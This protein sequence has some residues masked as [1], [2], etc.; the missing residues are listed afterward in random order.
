VE[1]TVECPFHGFRYESSGRCRL[2]PANGKN[3]SVPPRFQVSSYR[4]FEKHGFIWIWWG[5][6][7]PKEREPYFFEDIDDSFSSS[8]IVEGWK[9]HYSRAIENQLDVMHLPFV[10]R[11]TIGRGNRTLVNGP[12]AEWKSHEHLVVRPFNDIDNGQ[13]PL[14]PEQ[15]R[16]PYPPFHVELHF[17]NLWQNWI[18]ES[19]RIVV[20]FAPV[21]VE[22]TLLYLRFYQ[23][24]LRLPL[25]DSLVN[26]AFMRF[27][28]VVLHQDRRVVETQVPKPSG[29]K[30]VDS[31]LRENLVHGD[32]PIGAY[33]M[34]REEL[35]RESRKGS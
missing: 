6:D 1:H 33:R 32:G 3:A 31:S 29:L 7:P 27:N 24:F 23:K 20:A 5:D 17:P 11:T 10:H 15:I 16:P 9:T 4:T 13:E 26:A 12:V 22:N 14:K 8:L 19:M 28:R 2:I 35:I 25:L 18:S 34:R 21:D 30:A